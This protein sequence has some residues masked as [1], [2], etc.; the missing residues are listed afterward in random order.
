MGPIFP[1]SCDHEILGR[2]VGGVMVGC[3]LQRYPALPDSGG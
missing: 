1:T 3:V 2:V